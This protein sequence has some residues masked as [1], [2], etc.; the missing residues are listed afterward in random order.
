M[1]TRIDAVT[2]CVGLA[3]LGFSVILLYSPVISSAWVQPLLAVVLV[4][5][6][7]VSL[8]VYRKNQR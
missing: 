8:I 2:I 4:L 1:K 7:G 3:L 5:A 6:G